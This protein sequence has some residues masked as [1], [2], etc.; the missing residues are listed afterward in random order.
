[1]NWPEIPLE[2]DSLTVGRSASEFKI[3][4][5]SVSRPHFR[6]FREE[7]QWFVEDLDSRFGI[8]VNGMA[9]RRARLRD[10]DV[11]RFGRSPLYRMGNGK[12]APDSSGGGMAVAMGD[13]KI[14]VSP[15]GDEGTAQEW[16]RRLRG[17]PEP[18]TGR[19]TLLKDV[20]LEISPGEFIGI[21][22]PS[23]AGKSVLLEC[24]STHRVPTE[25]RI[26]LDGETDLFAN[27]DEVLPQIGSVPQQELI[28]PFLTVEE[29]LLHA[30]RLRL[31]EVE[32]ENVRR[33]EWVLDQ[34]EMTEHRHKRSGLL[35][36]G[37]QKRVNIGIELLRQP[38]LLLLDEPT[39]G[40]DPG[41][42]GNLMD[43]LRLL[44]RRNLTVIC[45]THTLDT[46]HYFDRVIAV[47]KRDGSGTIGFFGPPA[48]LLAHFQARDAGALFEKLQNLP[49]PVEAWEEST[50]NATA[51]GFIQPARRAK[52]VASMSH[53]PTA[54][55]RNTC[56]IIRRRTALGL[57]RDKVSL[58]I[59]L[60]L[61]PLLLAFLVVISQSGQ[62]RS[63]FI[64][65]FLVV[66]CLWM[67]M[68]LS[69]R[70]LVRERAS[71]DPGRPMLSL[72]FRDYLAGVRPNDYLLGKIL[73]FLPLV[74][75]QTLLIMLYTRIWVFLL[76]SEKSAN[77]AA[78]NDLLQAPFATGVAILLL[79]S[80]GGLVLGFLLSALARTERG[81]ISLLPLMVLPQLLLSRVAFGEGGEPWKDPSPFAPIANFGMLAREKAV[82]FTEW[83][84]GLLSLPMIT[85]PG[86]VLMDF[87]KLGKDSGILIGTEALYFF[88][89]LA[90]YGFALHWCYHRSIRSTLRRV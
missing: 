47:G 67:G 56:G 1:M 31:G 22:G 73:A 60:G 13:V 40:L 53:P 42:A 65:F 59:A 16:L 23:G 78:R 87:Q 6:L 51:S 41:L 35:S 57:R 11:L 38:R 71:L 46:I 20:N 89:L 72:F 30:A 70:E 81:A 43:R 77:A 2:Q 49:L 64:H 48:D 24:L 44:S 66:C 76:I 85:R 62:S 88:T 90:L 29:N 50:E 4:H 82:P 80:L 25:G 19:K 18:S 84:A 27:P 58:V 32:E 55:G 45:S 52:G 36:G 39:S 28:Y 37:Q 15:S 17:L 75:I 26:I 68:N 3:D 14:E 21:I 54:A 83:L 5:N 86:T 7:G 8:S 79:T 61:Q 74:A 69:V 63:V 10:D 33:V 9:V 12:L 34:I